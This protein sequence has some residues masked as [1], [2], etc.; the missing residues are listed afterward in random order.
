[1]GRRGG[2]GAGGG[3]GRYDGDLSGAGT[4]DVA[5]GNRTRNRVP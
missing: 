3:D 5:S 2:P 1:M 4:T